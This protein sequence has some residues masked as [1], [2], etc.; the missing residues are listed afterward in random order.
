MRHL[1]IFESISNDVLILI[2]SE[3]DWESL[4]INGELVSEGHN[5]GGGDRLYLLKM[6]EKY[7]FKS[8][9]VRIKYLNVDDDK[10]LSDVGSFPSS[11]SELSGKY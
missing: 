3:G 9:D 2:T 4:F 1:K 11:L 8:S 5:L 7:S 6:S 10:Y